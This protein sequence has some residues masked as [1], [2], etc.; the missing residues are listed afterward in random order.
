M[1]SRAAFSL[2]CWA[3]LLGPGGLAG[4]DWVDPDRSEP[5]G[6][7]YRTFLSKT[8][9]AEVSYLIYLPPDYA[10]AP[11]KRYP[12]VYWLHE[13]GGNQRSGA[14]FVAALDAAIQSG[15]A[16]AMIAVLVNGL[17]DSRYTDSFDGQRPVETVIIRDLIP[18]I[19]KTYRTIAVRE[20]R[21]LEGY[22]MG[23]F[24]AAHLGFRYPDL[25]GAVSIMAGALLD[26]DSAASM[27][28]ELFE[29]NFGGSKAYF[30]AGSPWVLAEKNAGRMRGRTFVRM[31]IGDRDPLLER[32]RDFDRLLTRLQ[33]GHEFFTVPHPAHD[34]RLFYEKLA[35]DAFA[36]YEK[37]V[38]G[39]RWP[40]AVW[41][42]NREADL[43]AEDGWL[44]LAG[45]FWLKEGS[46]R[47]GT[48]PSNE[49]VL[50]SGPP[51][52]GA[53][54]F[55]N[56]KATLRVERGATVSAGAGPASGAALRSDQP[57]PPDIVAVGDLSLYVIRR[58]ARYGVRVKDKNSRLRR[59]FAGLRWFP[60]QDSYRVTARFVPCEPPR[61]LAVPDITGG[62]ERVPSP[63]YAV[64]TLHHQQCRL[65]AVAEAGG[66][67]FIFQDLTSGKETYGGGRFLEAGPPQDGAVVLD[68]NKAYNP[69]CAYT[70]YA[71]CPLP[72][73]QNHLPVRIEAGESKY[74]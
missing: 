62:V 42:Q 19:D 3:L 27:H 73:K 6:T 23:G 71:T 11:G 68:F 70:P 40:A 50:P 39:A 2:V 24:G 25:F 4:M 55:H 61:I 43:L 32:N 49:I 9:H 26:D 60:I 53:F 69:P 12:V 22:S 65:D 56:G 37:A 10:A 44:T 17:R 66:L 54:E 45:L 8:I 16:P 14:P 34:T 13:L 38:G 63:G 33:I 28:P 15:K 51:H 36:F 30:H 57:G 35:P 20:A 46:N 47:F 29:K 5:A 58:G 41:R 72:P 18:H 31:G 64:F 48:D 7:K 67:F 1:D 74:H 52:A 21:A 59:E